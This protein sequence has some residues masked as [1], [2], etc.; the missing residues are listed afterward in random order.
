MLLFLLIVW[1]DLADLCYGVIGLVF[2]PLQHSS[3]ALP[4]YDAVVFLRDHSQLPLPVTCSSKG[5][6]GTGKDHFEPVEGF[7]VEQAKVLLEG[8]SRW[9]SWMNSL[10]L[11]HDSFSLH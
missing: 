10:K 6:S 9:C 5:I 11:S 4:G 7:W 8:F 2:F 3:L 1:S